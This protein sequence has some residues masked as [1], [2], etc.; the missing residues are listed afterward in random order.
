MARWLEL[1][2]RTFTGHPL[3]KQPLG[4]GIWG[5]SMFLHIDPFSAVGKEG[6]RASLRVSV[7]SHGIIPLCIHGSARPAGPACPLLPPVSSQV[8]FS[9]SSWRQELCL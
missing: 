2:F 4:L 6:P 9:L 8:S 5:S 1:S 3:D 7:L